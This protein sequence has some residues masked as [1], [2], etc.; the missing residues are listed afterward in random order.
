M[1]VNILKTV[2]FGEEIKQT[3]QEGKQRTP[4]IPVWLTP[5]S[6]WDE[7]NSAAGGIAQSH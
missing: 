7:V 4:W 6:G 2:S 3:R 1:H 5:D